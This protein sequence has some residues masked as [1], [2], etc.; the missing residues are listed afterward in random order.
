MIILCIIVFII[1]V[2]LWFKTAKLYNIP[3]NHVNLFS[4]SWLSILIGSIFFSLDFIVE[5]K[6]Y[7]VLLTSWIFFLLGSFKFKSSIIS[8]SNPT[9]Y[10]FKR[11]RIV[12][13]FLIILSF[14]AYLSSLGEIISKI[15]DISQWAA[16]RSEQTFAEATSENIFYTLFARNYSI[17]MPIAIFLFIKGE[18]SKKV[19]YSIFIYG[20]LTSIINFSRGPL[21]EF[22]LVSFVSYVLIKQSF[23]IPILKIILVIIVFIFIFIFSQSVLFSLNDY[24][25]FDASYQ[26]KMY[27][28]GGVNNYQLILDGLYPDKTAYSSPF[29]SFDFINYILKRLSLIDSYP[30]QVRAFN[31]F[32]DGSNVYTYLDAFTLDFGIIGAFIGSFFIGYFSKKVYFKYDNNKSIVSLIIYSIICYFAVMSF[33]N[34]EY[35]RFSFLLFIIKI[36]IIELII[37]FPENIV[38]HFKINNI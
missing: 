15:T 34:N 25:V 9:E 10:R 38:K 30:E 18:L 27:L 1:G 31:N 5:P 22:V 4:L 21:L 29:Y 23:K 26:I 37:R 14:L 24:S 12:L 35:I 20:L 2:I 8:I 6:T 3:V 17:Y 13:Y 28:F 16:V 7:L 11:I 36:Y 33:I 32:I 19:F